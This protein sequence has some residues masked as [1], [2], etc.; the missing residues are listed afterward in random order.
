MKKSI[1]YFFIFITSALI[2]QQNSTNAS[3][4]ESSLIQK[5]KLVKNSLVK[6]IE[7]TNIGPTVM[8]GRVADVDVNPNNT[9]EFYV[10]YASGGLWYTNNNGTTF[11]PVLDNSPTQNIGDIAV[12]WNSETIWVGTGEKNSSRSSYAGIGM[13]KSTNKGKTWQNVGLTD[14]H[15]VSR[16]LINPNNTDEV[17]VGVIGHLY[18]SN[19]ERG[20]FK[21]TNG[22]ETWT[23]S[24]FINQ[25][26]GIID[27]DFAPENF[28]TMYAASWERER[29]AWNFDGDGSNSAIYKSTD[30][31][32]SWT[33]IGDKSGFPI[34]D[35]VGRIGLTVFNENTVYALHDSQFRR[36][37]ENDK[38][39]SDELT[40]E[41]FKTMSSD[42]FLKI[43]DKKLN[44]YLKNNGFQEKY[45]AQNV[46]QMV[47]VGSV[48]PMDLASYLEDANAMLFDTQVIGAE[49]FKTTNGGK[50][51]KK[52]HDNFLEG[53]YSSYGYYFG[54][55]RV[56]LQDENGIYVLG[57]PIIKSK[58]GGK[59]F[60]SI[61]AENVH[62]D[63]QAL[64]V[65]PKKSGHI[66][67]GN[68]G[69]LNLSYDD[70]ENWI[71][72]NDPAVGQFYSVYADNQKNYKVYGGLQDNGVWVAENNARINKSW[73]QSGQ[74]PYESIM[75]GDGM[76]VQV[77]DRNPNIVYT[78]YQ[79]G[80][81]FRI[82]R[83]SGKNEY[84]QPKHTLGENP[85]RFN[86]QT[87][88]HLSKHNQDILY[89]GGN[90]LHRSLNKGDDWETISDDLTTGGKKGNV[91]YGTL[92]SISESPFQFGLIYVGSDDGYINFTKNGG[93]SWTRI[94]NNLPQ[95]LWVSRVIASSHKK[96]RLYATLNGYRF[97][98][99]TPYVYM[100]NDYGQTWKNIGNSIPT[101]S[102]NVIKE[103]P[104]NEN[105]LYLGTDDGLYISFNQ[106]ASWEVFSKNLP[107]VAVHDLV[108]Q[109]TAKHLIVGTHGRSLYKAN[110][111][112]LQKMTSDIL[113]KSTHIFSVSDIRKNRN[114]GRSWSQ[115]RDTYEPEITIPFYANSSRKVTVDIY[116][117]EILV[118]SFSMNADK[119]YNESDFNL[120]FSK[121]GLKDYKKAN[122][123]ATINAAQNDVFYLPKGKYVVK[124]GDDKNEFEIK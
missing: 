66:L 97:D 79:F 73:Q 1:F 82:D 106:G 22:G 55:I 31:G 3:T 72:L 108:I 6:N 117:K 51:W 104:E 67:N 40:K 4:I 32:T 37:K 99:F 30:A 76:Q 65:N 95:N 49:V 29:K 62:S 114:W 101:S 77:D 7:F 90:K 23:K 71:K 93:G 83:E 9:T 35:G 75:G 100:S 105:L 102:V 24:L 107:N 25:D 28:N 54:E 113:S 86:W 121:K 33:K 94:S 115:W 111:E 61:S 91:A 63:H 96:E 88:I 18:S 112:P 59:T 41:D 50:S 15:H 70:G 89:L 119:G 39:P 12:D 2:S 74:N 14:S 16:I 20:V 98:D 60:T 53:V 38:K 116:Q 64:W 19:E 8:S 21:T 110:I 48:K 118:N 103:D 57:V 124:I 69:G 43:E 13:L 56:D 122:N 45:R 52:T 87:P 120:T 36:P 17:I 81:Y 34:G 84:I 109:P 27:I 85:Y 10:G 58:D 47:R 92:T 44:S 80:N 68:D 123:K 42:D 78:G 11:T 5:E 26:T 46:K